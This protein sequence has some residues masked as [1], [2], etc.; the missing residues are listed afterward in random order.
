MSDDQKGGRDRSGD[1]P[2]RVAE[3]VL[4]ELQE[5]WLEMCADAP[6]GQFMDSF[7]SPMLEENVD[8]DFLENDYRN[9][10][11][12]EGPEEKIP[13]SF[14]A[15]LISCAY[16]M[17]AVKAEKSGQTNVAWSYAADARRWAGLSLGDRVGAERVKAERSR[18]GK[19]GGTA[20]SDTFVPARERARELALQ[21]NYKS[22]KNAIEQIAPQVWEYARQNNIIL[23]ENQLPKTM[24]KWL[25]GIPFGSKRGMPSG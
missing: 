18:F 17:Q 11:A 5:T 19:S 4:C 14:A 8:G 13:F 12:A 3:L 16:A 2:R 1:N 22:R 9:A 25:E 24:E 7:I 10:T 20:R 23:S 6:E 21:K 15:I